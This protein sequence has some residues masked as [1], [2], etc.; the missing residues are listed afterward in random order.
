MALVTH[1]LMT[2]IRILLLL[3]YLICNVIFVTKFVHV[4]QGLNIQCRLS[5]TESDYFICV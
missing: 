2:L 4:Y 5:T 3:Y 1:D